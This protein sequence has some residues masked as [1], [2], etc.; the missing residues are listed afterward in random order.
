MAYSHQALDKTSKFLTNSRLEIVNKLLDKGYL[1]L[2]D[3]VSDIECKTLI[4]DLNQIRGIYPYH[5]EDIESYAGVFRSPFVFFDSYRKLLLTKKFHEI[6]S[7]LFPTNYQ[8]HLSRCVENHPNKSAATIEW[9]RDIPYLHTPSKFPL[10][11]SILTFL[12]SCEDIQIE[13]KLNSHKDFF[14]D[15]EKADTLSLNPKPGDTLIFDS[16]LVHRT[17]PTNKIVLYNLYM[18]TSPI[19]KP[20]INYSSNEIISTISKNKFR[21]NEINN[22]IGHQ[23]LVPKDDLEYL[24]KYR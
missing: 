17:L 4:N 23:Y 8:L 6:L 24:D 7:E 11:I 12:S 9:H 16:N 14:Y 20:V 3:V 15:F 2:E 19:L 21:L 22:I 1:I 18:F 13:I 5:V 10:S